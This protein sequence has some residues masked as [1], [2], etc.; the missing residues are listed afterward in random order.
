[1]NINGRNSP[2]CDTTMKEINE[3]YPISPKPLTTYEYRIEKK[4]DLFQ[5]SDIEYTISKRFCM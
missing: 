4:Y 1:M 5:D 3:I 2:A